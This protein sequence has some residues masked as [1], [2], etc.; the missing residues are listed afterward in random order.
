MHEKIRTLT[1]EHDI[2][3]KTIDQQSSIIL[4]LQQTI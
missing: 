2:M 4:K 3:K 1:S